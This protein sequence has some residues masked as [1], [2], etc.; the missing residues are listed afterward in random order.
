VRERVTHQRHA[1]HH[2][3]AAEQTAIQSKQDA[4]EQCETQRRIAEGEEA[5]GLIGDGGLGEIA[6]AGGVSRKCKEQRE[7]SEEQRDIR[8]SR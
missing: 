3:E 5:K 1:P 4:A 7:E 6:D 2:D 8:V